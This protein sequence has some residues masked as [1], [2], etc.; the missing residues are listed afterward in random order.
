[1][2]GQGEAGLGQG[3][4]ELYEGGPM[5]LLALILAFAFCGIEPASAAPKVNLPAPAQCYFDA[6]AMENAAKVASC[7]SGNAFVVDGNKRTTGA[8]AIAEWADKRVIGGAY[9]LLDVSRT[10]EGVRV[11]VRFTP[12]GSKK[13]FVAIGSVS[14]AERSVPS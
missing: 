7:M 2:G 1:V 4:N 12:R 9:T 14:V 3:I 10:K 11:V 6:I 8:A 13:G 5:P